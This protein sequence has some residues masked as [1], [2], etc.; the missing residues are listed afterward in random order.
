MK[1][2]SAEAKEDA[3][4]NDYPFRQHFLEVYWEVVADMPQML[5]L[6]ANIA[7]YGGGAHSNSSFDGLVWDRKNAKA[8]KAEDFFVSQEAMSKA[9]ARSYCP[10]LNKIREKRRGRAVKQGSNDSFDSCPKMCELT[11]LPASSQ[12]KSFNRFVML[13]APYIAG[14]YVEGPYVVHIRIDAATIDALKPAC[15]EFFS[16]SE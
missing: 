8:L 9:L 13:A 12:G 15:R 2:Q 11:I 10:A 5:S 6:S 7:S 1:S 3:A 4:A 14:P 16:V